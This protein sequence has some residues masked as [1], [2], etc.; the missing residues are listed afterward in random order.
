MGR[1]RCRPLD[2]A[3]LRVRGVRCPRTE[4]RRS[5][6]DH[7]T[8]G[9]A[10]R[11]RSTR[12]G[13][14]PRFPQPGESAGV[15]LE[16]HVRIVHQHDRFD[17]LVKL[18]VAIDEGE[19]GGAIVGNMVV[20]DAERADGVREFEAG[21]PV[22]GLDRPGA[23]ERGDADLV[24]ERN[25]ELAVDELMRFAGRGSRAGP[26][27]ADRRR[28]GRGAG[29]GARRAPGARPSHRALLSD[30]HADLLGTEAATKGALA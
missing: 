26:A 9:R 8:S 28:D 22:R 20:D 12:A 15:V 21:R 7:G 23:G 18:V 27:G 10:D 6:G 2:D 1:D 29:R 13:L 17:V 16:H 30:R 11:R 14:E 19:P 25:V 24:D 4:R 3:A 5:G